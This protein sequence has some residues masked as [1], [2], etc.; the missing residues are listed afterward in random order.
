MLVS[1]LHKPTL[2]ALAFARATRPDTLTAL[3]VNVDDDETRALLAEWER[4]D[5]PVPLTVLESPYR[6]IT[7][8]VVGY[9]KQLRRDRPRD[10]VSVFI[11]EYV[12]GHWW[13]HLLHNQSALRLKGRLLFQPG[14]MV[15]SVPWQLDSSEGGPQAARRPGPDAAAHA[16]RPA[17]RRR[18]GAS[19]ATRRRRARRQPPER[20]RAATVREPSSRRPDLLELDGRARS[21]TA[22]TAW[23]G[24][25][26]AGS[27][28]VRHA[29]PGERVRA[30]VTEDRGGGVLPGRRGRGADAPRRT[31]STP[32][33]PHAGPGRCGG[34]DWQ[35]ASARPRS[36]SSRRRS[37]ASSSPGWPGSTCRSL[38]DGRGAAGRACSAGAPGSPTPSTGRAAS[39]CTG[40]A[41]TSVE[42]VD[43]LPARRARRRRRRRRCAHAGRAHRRRGRAR[44]R[45][46]A[47]TVLAHRP[48][49][50]TAGRG[51]R[52]PD[53]V[54][55]RRRAGRG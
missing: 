27:C 3:T 24:D 39:A 33:C 20:E 23:P 1:K 5:L 29:L 4:H 7:R 52:P 13:E 12:V 41:R 42:P 34:C 11:P 26:T 45:R 21:R 6:E 55:V 50:R 51:R 36:A 40:T 14:V 8:P 37:C 32:P 15:T 25:E 35:H 22:G 30:V 16:P 28:F 17:R 47:I 2:R 9:V 46:R 54:E 44:R 53:R 18:R 10:V 48:G 38:V 19:D 43:A 31:G 49:R